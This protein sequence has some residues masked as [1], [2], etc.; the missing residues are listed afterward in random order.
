MDDTKIISLPEKK[1][2][3]DNLFFN[4]NGVEQVTIETA[5]NGYSFNI[6]YMDGTTQL[7]VCSFNQDVL[8]LI[9]SMYGEEL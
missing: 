2:G 5:M 1:K 3:N 9:K 6:Y 8:K 4:P 7:I